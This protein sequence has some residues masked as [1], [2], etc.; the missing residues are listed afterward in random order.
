[1]APAEI[2]L[3][4]ELKGR[5]CGGYKFRR[6]FSIKNYVV[7]F[8]CPEI[9][10]AIEVDGETHYFQRSIVYDQKR[11][12]YLQ[13]LGVTVLRIP[14]LD[15]QQNIDGVIQTILESVSTLKSKDHSSRIPD[16][17]HT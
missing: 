12:A 3:W 2:M 16:P 6:Q 15:I 17:Q 4:Q 1:M 5:K 13:R 10:L 8:Y 14:N 11:Q 7:D 9:K